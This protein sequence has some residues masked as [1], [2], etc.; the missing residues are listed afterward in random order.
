[1]SKISKLQEKI[2]ELQNK[3]NILESVA[4]E[5]NDEINYL[6]DKIFAIEEM[7][8]RNLHYSVRE[9]MEILKKEKEIQDILKDKDYREYFVDGEKFFVTSEGEIYSARRKYTPS[10]RGAG[11][12]AV[13][14]NRKLKY[15]HRVVW[16]AFNGPVPEGLELDHLNTIRCDNRLENLRACT[17]SE[18]KRNPLTLA[19]YRISNK[20][21]GIVR[22][23]REA[24]E[25]E[26]RER[27]ERE[28]AELTKEIFENVL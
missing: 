2:N 24:K 20:N 18:N 10:D 16:E 17:S 22:Y 6:N 4:S 28:K 5:Y 7:E 14:L 3:A 23:R 21:K 26:E 19:K 13:C 12:M 9:F 25:R 8:R 15:V 1:M 11:Y 27:L